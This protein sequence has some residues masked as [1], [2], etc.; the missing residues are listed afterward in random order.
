MIRCEPVGRPPRGLLEQIHFIYNTP[1]S[2]C[3]WLP[4]CSVSKASEAELGATK[5]DCYVHHA[6][7]M[8]HI[9]TQSL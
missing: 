1:Q 7:S 3:Y 6:V 5:T 8:P 2:D 4:G 9:C